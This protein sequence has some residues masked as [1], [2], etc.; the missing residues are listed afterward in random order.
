MTTRLL[1]FGVAKKEYWPS[2]LV[3][4]LVGIFAV[5]YLATWPI[6]LRYP[7]EENRSEGIA[8]AEM[9]RLRR[10]FAV[11]A[12]ASA[13]S[14]QAANYGPLY[15]LVGAR[16]VDPQEPT[17]LPLRL[18][19]MLATLGCAAGCGALAFWV[20]RRPLA[21]CLGPLLFLSYAFVTRHG[22]SARSDLGALFLWFS[23]FLVACRLQ[24]SRKL[25]WAV[26][27][28]VAGFFYKQQFVAAPL[29]VL[30]FLVLEKRYRL[31]S[32]FAGLLALAGTVLLGFFQFVV[33]P[34]QA[35]VDHF[36][37]YNVWPFA[38][39]RV[40][41]SLWSFGLLLVFPLW[42]GIE[43]LRGHRQ[44]L[45][46]CYVGFAIVINMVLFWRIGSDTHYFLESFIVLCS[47]AAGLFAEYVRNPIRGAKWL[48]LLGCS[49]LLSLGTTEP[50]PQPEDFGRDRAIQD[51]LHS[52][53][54]PHS[55]AL[56]FYAGDLV[57]AGLETP[58][59]DLYAY[60]ENLRMNRI[61]GEGLKTQFR[62]QRFAV[63]TTYID[64]RSPGNESRPDAALIES[65]RDEI[66]DHYELGTTLEL[67]RPE[68]VRSYNRFY[69]W[70]PRTGAPPVGRAAPQ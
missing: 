23:G 54:A 18:L 68:M 51:F 14:F 40:L 41:A 52:K 37:F 34:G 66:L 28:M 39:E 6:L 59:T 19:S 35:F 45:L 63:V 36:L 22:L 42:L 32:Q 26:P 55:T 8:L 62:R 11:Y 17:Y 12:P 43:Y 53:F 15:F 25:L 67:P 27:L 21:A 33:F 44:P 1:R 30:L 4:L 20:S 60:S 65:V 7:G 47:L 49:L 13:E 3:F 61:P 69:A 9:V 38:W 48:A 57:R 10:G 24:E 56:G 64:L 31:A 5:R 2:L 16:L 29:A 70:A 46:A 58:I 50:V